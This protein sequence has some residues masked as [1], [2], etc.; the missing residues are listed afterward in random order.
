MQ[1]IGCANIFVIFLQWNYMIGLLQVMNSIFF[2]MQPHY[3]AKGS[4]KGHQRCYKIFLL[5]FYVYL[6]LLVQITI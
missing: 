1:S 2:V 6:L 5:L 4:D 3:C